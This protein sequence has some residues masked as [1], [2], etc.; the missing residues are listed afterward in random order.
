MTLTALVLHDFRRDEKQ[1]L[2]VK[3]EKDQDPSETAFKIFM[4]S[5]TRLQQYGTGKII[6]LYGTSN[7]GKTSICKEVLAIHSDIVVDGI[8]AAMDRHYLKIISNIGSFKKYFF[9]RYLT[10][11]RCIDD[12][13]ISTFVKGHE[14]KYKPLSTVEERK[15]AL[16]AASYVSIIE[17]LF[18][19][20]THRDAAQDNL[21]ER[22]LHLSANEKNVVIDAVECNDFFGYKV[23][24]MFHCPLLITLVHCSFVKLAEHKERRN[25]QALEIDQEHDARFG[26]YPF[27]QFTDF[28]RPRRSGQ[29]AYMHSVNKTTVTQI[30]DKHLKEECRFRPTPGTG[31]EDLQGRRNFELG[32]LYSKLGLKEDLQEEVQLT[33]RGYFDIE[34]DTGVDTPAQGALKVLQFI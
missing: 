3:P 9:D 17:E 30:Y 19:S 20:A 15:N 8:D 31:E 2:V 34:I 32:I 21:F 23:S 7:A 25:R 27:L 18:F 14:V 33:S 10:I 16:A 13:D 22:A 5:S 1:P 24:R 6:F 11:S 12:D 28:L 4:V 26:T 29:E